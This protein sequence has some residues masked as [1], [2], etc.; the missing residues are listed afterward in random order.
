MQIAAGSNAKRIAQRTG[1]A[2]STVRTHIKRLM[3]KTGV[4]RQGDLVRLLLTL[5]P[6]APQPAV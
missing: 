1:V 2:L 4:D 5:P 6:S 3:H